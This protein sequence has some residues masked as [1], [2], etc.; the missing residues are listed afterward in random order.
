M[1]QIAAEAPRPWH[2]LFVKFGALEPTVLGKP[3]YY[4]IPMKKA[5]VGRFGFSVQGTGTFRFELEWIKVH[6]L[7]T[8]AVVHHCVV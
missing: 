6:S 8:F 5:A 3:T 4:T 7:I 2:P 1:G